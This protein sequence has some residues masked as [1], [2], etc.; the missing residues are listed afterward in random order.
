MEGLM[1]R[2]GMDAVRAIGQSDDPVCRGGFHRANL[3]KRTKKAK[4]KEPARPG[5]RGWIG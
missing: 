5:S 4:L 2:E 1:M 3:E